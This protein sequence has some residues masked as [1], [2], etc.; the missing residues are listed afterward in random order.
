[1]SEILKRERF[2]R[3][4][5]LDHLVDGGMAKICRARF[6]GEQADKVVAIKMVQPQYSKDEGFKTMFM[7]EI[8]VTFG[9]LHPN[10]IQTYDYGLNK[11]QL[12]VAMEY[13]DGRNLKECL[14]KLKDRKFVFPIEISTYII[15]QACQGLYYAHTFRDK[16][17]GLEASIVHRDISPHNIMLSY[18]GSVKIIDFGIA[19]SQTNSEATQAG[20]I[21][22]KLS[23]LAPEYLEGLELDARYDQFALGITLWEMLCSRKLF[24]ENNDLAVLKKIQECKIP[25][26]SS[27][28]PNVP[29]ELDDIVL[30]AL[31]KDRNK[32]FDNLDQM[33][34]ALMKFLYAKFPD[35]NATDLSYFSQELFREEIKKDRE[36]MFEFGK[37]DLRPYLDEVR[38][39]QEGGTR[40]NSDNSESAIGVKD[41]TSS[42]LKEK[43][44]DLE[45][46]DFSD[47]PKENLKETQPARK[48]GTSSQKGN[49]TMVS[50]TTSQSINLKEKSKVL[51]GE[52][53]SPGTR[54]ENTK[55]FVKKGDGTRT[56][57]K[58]A[59]TAS[60]EKKSLSGTIAALLAL[61]VGIG[62]YINFSSNKAEIKN[63]S[64]VSANT[65]KKDRQPAQANADA[66]IAGDIDN[67]KGNIV[68][69]HFDKQKMQIFVDG[70]KM[71][72][73]LLSNLKVPLL[74]D[75]VLRVQIEGKKHFIKEMR[76]DNTSAVEVEIPEMPGIAYGYVNTSSSCAE[77]EIRFE[78]YG[79]KRVSPI[80][81]VETF[82]IGFPLGLDDKGKIT[83]MNYEIFF[84]KKGEDIERKIELTITR[85]DQAIDLCDHF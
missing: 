58:K 20:T 61:V 51:S 70:K 38:R 27:I 30:K 35:F 23:Y 56:Q 75:F 44:L 50:N 33:N 37:I 46:E 32:R 3:Y 16:L 13:C 11:G 84:K 79:E 49:A 73:D 69:S 76:V 45:F 66:D 7:D 2:G 83:P 82:G 67:R 48:L 47:S 24:K 39:E 6:L 29:K 42:K 57:I 22:G 5:I 1:M 64:P 14:E 41:K 15:S 77:G 8:K 68:L 80:P 17:T 36:K 54:V 71:E 52:P 65:L 28:N 59:I 31:S 53:S 10:V 19:K 81:M 26:P 4:L 34:R 18:D 78:V 40:E 43:I 85:E 55:S 9:L 21:K 62:A 25:I 74:R 72:V 12:F 63:S 60:P